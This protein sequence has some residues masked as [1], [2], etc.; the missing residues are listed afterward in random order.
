[1][2]TMR[3]NRL[4]WIGLSVVLCLLGAYLVLDS[5]EHPGKFGE[6]FILFGGTMVALALFTASLA[7]IQHTQMKA[8]ARHMRHSSRA[9]RASRSSS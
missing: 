6:A 3:T 2:A 5:I 9:T 7:L 4:F 1:M 8:L